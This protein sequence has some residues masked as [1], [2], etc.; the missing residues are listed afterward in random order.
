MELIMPANHGKVCPGA[1]L[2][3]NH[4]KIFDQFFPVFIN[5]NQG[6]LSGRR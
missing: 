4:L 6:M 2:W 1:I 3:F 5:Q